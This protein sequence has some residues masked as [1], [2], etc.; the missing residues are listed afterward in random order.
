MIC[1][2][3][4]VRHANISRG[5]CRTC[6]YSDGAAVIREFYK[7]TP[8]TRPDLKNCPSL[9]G[10]SGYDQ[11]NIAPAADPDVGPTTAPP[12]SEGKIAV[13]ARRAR[14]GYSVFHPLDKRESLS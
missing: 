7:K 14:R 4:K 6:Y 8:T 12:G 13:M 9:S 2:H 5:L 11:V 3:C 1:L 10:R